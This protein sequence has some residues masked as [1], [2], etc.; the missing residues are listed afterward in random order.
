MQALNQ[1]DQYLTELS[2]KGV[3]ESIGRR[4]KEA[5]D[6]DLSYS[7]F[8]NTILF[9]EV[10]FRQNARRQRLLKAA[11]F[12]TQA[13]LEGI[14]YEKVR[15]LDKRQVQEIAQLNFLEDGINIIVFGATGVGKTYL[16]TAIGNHACRCGR[17]V[18]F[19]KMNV[20][21]EKF[22]LAR[23]EG[24][25]LNL[26]KKI[27]SAD[28]II[29][30]DFG[31]K[32]LTGQQYQDFYDMLGERESGKSTILTTQ[33]PAE[34][35]NEVIPDPLVCEAIS[36]RLTARAIK[37]VLRGPSKRGE[38]KKNLTVNKEDEK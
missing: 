10:Q 37:L 28:L 3:R 26:L 23:A 19:W 36:D 20:L 18:L 6:A 30:D 14:T 15:S 5:L 32:A 31:I 35:W 22:A 17:S 38:A 11:G 8:L 29:V 9:D 7:D 2:L 13:S 4:M 34:N 12:R 16:A 24:T 27:S 21:L 33:L 25:Y 1:T